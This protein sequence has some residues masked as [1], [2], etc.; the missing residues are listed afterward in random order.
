MSIPNSHPVYS[1]TEVIMPF[2]LPPCQ[3][4]IGD[5]IIGYHELGYACVPTRNLATEFWR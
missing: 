1:S 5:L 3:R 4:M 2:S